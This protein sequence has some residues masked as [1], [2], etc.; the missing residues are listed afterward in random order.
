MTLNNIFTL[1]NISFAIKQLKVENI[2][3]KEIQKE[4]LD[5]DY[6]P[7]ANEKIDMKIGEKIRPI[8]LASTKDKII[9]RTLLNGLK[10][11]DKCLSNKSYAYRPNK[12]SLKAINRTTDYLK[13]G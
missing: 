4:V 6:V 11:F 8:T 12:S 3:T 9:Q 10:E 2:D 1:D 13:R 7:F 5:G